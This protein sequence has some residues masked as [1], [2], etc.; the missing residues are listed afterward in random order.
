MAGSGWNRVVV[1]LGRGGKGSGVVWVRLSRGW[2]PPNIDSTA[3]KQGN[4]ATALLRGAACKSIYFSK[5]G[6]SSTNIEE[7]Y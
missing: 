6:P 3:G 2:A 4:I 7:T 1:E 5:Y